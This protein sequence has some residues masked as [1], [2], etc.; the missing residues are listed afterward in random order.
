[1]SV[2]GNAD[3]TLS[4]TD[5]VAK[6]GPQDPDTLTHQGNK[7]VG[8]LLWHYKDVDDLVAPKEPPDDHRTTARSDPADPV[9]DHGGRRRAGH[10]LRA[11]ALEADR[12]GFCARTRVRLAG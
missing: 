10:G 2:G 8:G 6:E 5:Q 4:V 7:H 12:C 9:H 11:T 3:V 1:M